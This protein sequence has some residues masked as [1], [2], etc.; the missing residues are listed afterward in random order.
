MHFTTRVSGIAAVLLAILS[1]GYGQSPTDPPSTP[2]PE[3]D[4]WTQQELTGDW[5]GTRSRWK[6]KG[7]ELEFKLSNFFQG[8]A[9]GGLEEGS[10]YTGKFEYT[11]KFDLGKVAGWKYWS[12]EIKAEA[13]WGGPVLGGVGSINPVNTAAITP[14]A[15]GEVI[16]VTAVNFTRIIPKDLAKG[17]LFVVSF[18]RFNLLDLVDEDF[19]GGAGDERFFNI[20]QIGP[21]TVLRQVPLVA[22][23]ASFA[24]VKHGEPRFSIAVID[25]NDHTLDPGLDDLFADGVTLSPTVY[26]PVKYFGK[27]AKHSFGGAVTTKKY[28]PFDAIRQVIIP[29][30]PVNPVE[31]QRGS[32]SI[33]YVFRQ[34]LVERG[35][36]DG[37]G[38]FS[39]VSIADKATSPIT[40]F[41]DVGL[42]GNGLIKSRRNDEF[43]VTY[44]YT[45]LSSVLKDNINLI[46][47]GNRGLRV[48]HQF[49]AFYNLHLTPWLRLTGD[50]QIIRPTRRIADTA[51]V[52]GGRLVMLF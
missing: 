4:F 48:E 52:P 45:D 46:T 19:F 34:Y 12:S 26:F 21:L 40:R 51:V 15:A 37:W 10:E 18:G 32:W 30:P 33:S 39:Q 5:G 42:G 13:R 22:N 2:A 23:G 28:T 3:P 41:F 8:V 1:V 24:Y 35:P 16:S 17:D 20:A 7:I 47:I 11:M 38:F 29:G 25:P 6:E 43:G 49:E 36:K 9:S 31:P 14:G 50:L 44:A 27:T